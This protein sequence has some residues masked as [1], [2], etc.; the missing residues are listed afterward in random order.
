MSR[1]T[2]AL[3]AISPTD[4]SSQRANRSSTLRV[5]RNTRAARNDLRPARPL[6][7]TRE[8]VRRPQLDQP[9]SRHM[10][11]PDWWSS[12]TPQ[13][14]QG[15]DVGS[16]KGLPDGRPNGL[17]DGVREGSGT[18]KIGCMVG[19]PGVNPNIS[20]SRLTARIAASYHN[21]MSNKR[22]AFQGAPGAS[23]AEALYLLHP[24]ATSQ[25][26]REFRDVVDAVLGGRAGYGLLPIENSLAGSVATNFDLIAESGLVVVAEVVSA[27]HH[28]L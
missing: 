8:G 19:G 28:C 3:F 13:S 11:H 18:G 2:S 6:V 17:P 4:S 24:D 12:G 23:S 27:V 16:P 9:H 5:S 25:P 26:Q 21:A 7:E 10:R 20:R 1:A 14:G 22:I 15:R